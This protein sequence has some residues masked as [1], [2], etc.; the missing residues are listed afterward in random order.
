MK[1]ALLFIVIGFG[2]LIGGFIVGALWF[3]VSCK[4]GWTYQTMCRNVL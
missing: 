2:A 4:V 1:T 3:E